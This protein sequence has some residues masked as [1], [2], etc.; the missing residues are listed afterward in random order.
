MTDL[1]EI[2]QLASPTLIVCRA[3]HVAGHHPDA[4]FVFLRSPNVIVARGVNLGRSL[5]TLAKFHCS[6]AS[7]VEIQKSTVPVSIWKF[8]TVGF[9]QPSKFDVLPVNFEG[10]FVF[11]RMTSR[12]VAENINLKRTGI[13]AF[14]L[15]TPTPFNV[16]P[17]ENSCRQGECR[18]IG[19]LHA[20]LGIT[21]PKELS[22][23]KP[24]YADG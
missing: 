5:Q 16:R 12:P 7:S 20:P 11:D 19:Q 23:E 8:D 1:F 6:I 18:I 17:R 24:N 22:I 10:W 15:Q 14:D 9:L 3:F 13:L 21:K 4:L 2:S